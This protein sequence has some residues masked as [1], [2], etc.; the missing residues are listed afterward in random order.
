M[1]LPVV[2]GRQVLAALHRAGF[3]LDHVRG[4]HHI[5]CSPGGARAT[6]PVHAGNTLAPKT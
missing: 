1:K 4:S 3:V 2:T 5:L 6:V